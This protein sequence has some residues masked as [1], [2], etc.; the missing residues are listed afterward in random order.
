VEAK[1]NAQEQ[2]AV[3]EKK[4]AEKTAATGEAKEVKGEQMQKDAKALKKH[5][6]TAAEGARMDRAGA[7]EKANGEKMEDSAKAH[8]KHAKKTQKAANEMEKS[9]NKIEKA[10]TEMDKK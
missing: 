7:A 3:H 2:K 5:D 1:G 9:G 4:A 6:N 8:K 10:G